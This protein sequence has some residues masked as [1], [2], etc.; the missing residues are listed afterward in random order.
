MR[1]QQKLFS[2]SDKA[3]PSQLQSALLAIAEPISD[4]IGTFVII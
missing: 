2:T 1:I 4:A 3:S